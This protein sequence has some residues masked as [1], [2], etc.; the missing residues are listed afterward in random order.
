MIGEAFQNVGLL[1][2]DVVVDDGV[3]GLAGRNGALDGADEADELL[4]PMAP[5]AAP[6]HRCVEDDE[7]GEQRRRVAALVVAG[8]PP[9]FA[10]RE[11]QAGRRAVGGLNSV[12]LV[13]RRHGRM[14]GRAIA[15]VGGR[16]DANSLRPADRRAHRSAFVN[17]PIVSR[18]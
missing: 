17:R 2:G 6:D 9:A 13:D 11:R 1:A 8:H 10:V 16:E 7:R 12:F 5:H 3:D 18:H 4:A 14:L 15:I